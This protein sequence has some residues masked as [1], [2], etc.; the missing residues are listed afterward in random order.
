ML[1]SQQGVKE[2]LSL[3]GPAVGAA[4][5]ADYTIK[6]ALIEQGDTFFAYTDGLTDATNPTDESFSE[7]VF[8]TCQV[9]GSGARGNSRASS[10][11]WRGCGGL[12]RPD[13]GAAQTGRPAQFTYEGH[14]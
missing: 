14:R 13:A 3:T 6:E 12:I 4:F 11:A 7:S 8:S 10:D 9:W 1:I 2:L 5:G